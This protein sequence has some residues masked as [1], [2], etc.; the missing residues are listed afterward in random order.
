MKQ[1]AQE[2][3]ARLVEERLRALFVAGLDGDELAYRGFLDSL[4]G[5][6]RGFLR[7]RIYYNQGDIED[8]VQ[9]I[10][11]AVHNSR[12]TYRGSE[13]LNLWVYAIASYK[14]NDIYRARSPREALNK[15]LDDH[16]HIFGSSDEESANAKRDIGL[17]LDQLPD[18]HR[19]PI[20]HVKLRGLSVIETAKLTGMSQ[21]M[22]KAGI[23]RGLQ[24]LAK[25][26]RNT[27]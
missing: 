4:T 20:F 8:I 16:L 3:L 10:L 22:I 14:L 17:L 27:E 18:S 15:P 7:K 6:L 21:F 26:I 24:M 5:H 9:E 19:L 13:P 11:L 12:H 23:Y 25:K 2:N 1:T